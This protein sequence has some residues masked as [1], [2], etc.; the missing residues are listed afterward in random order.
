MPREVYLVKVGMTM[1]EGMVSEWYIPDGGEVKK[2]DLL[3][4][5]E[6]EKVNLDVDAEYT[7]KV[8]HLVTAGLMLKPGDVVGYIYEQGE[9]IPE[10]A[11]ALAN[12]KPEGI[13]LEDNPVAPVYEAGTLSGARILSSPAARRLAAELGV[14]LGKI[15]GSGPGNRIIEKDVLAASASSRMPES[16]MSANQDSVKASPLARRLAAEKGI[17]LTGVKGTGPRGRVT[18][19]DIESYDES[20]QESGDGAVRKAVSPSE[21]IIPHTGMRKTIARRMHASLAGSAQLTMNM[22]VNMDEAI[23]MRQQ[24]TREW[25]P[26]GIR[27]TY[28]DMVVLATAKALMLHPVMNS[29]YLD[30]GILMQETVNMGIAVALEEGLVV[31]V[32]HDVQRMS[33][34]DVCIASASLA[35]TAR[36][37]K[38]GLDDFAE[39]TF[40]VSSLGMYRVETFSPILNEPQTGILG[41]NAITE[42][43]RWQGDIPARTMTM[44]LSLTWD[45]RVL[46]GVPAAI[47]LGVVRDILEQPY[48][49]LV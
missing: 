38:L 4:A 8:K 33:L 40:T 21:H 47:F 22:S 39:G 35:K 7:G 13:V 6:T 34:K 43:V 49:L 26:E 12:H 17:D 10:G 9:A 1:T 41:V 11:S 20:R 48:R 32:L 5:L 46:D 44:N 14:D 45:H 2:G 28:T 19:E 27:P 36:E 25:E 42:S 30:E 23:K 3:Y 15:K 31:P 16:G 18:R 24:L 37:G 29:Q